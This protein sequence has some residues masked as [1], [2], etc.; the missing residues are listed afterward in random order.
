MNKI[1]KEYDLTYGFISESGL[2]ETYN[3]HFTTIGRITDFIERYLNS[4]V[5]VESDK[6]HFEITVVLVESE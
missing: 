4:R 5:W 3:K 2:I 6:L 1:Y